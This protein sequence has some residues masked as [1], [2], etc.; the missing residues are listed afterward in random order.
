MNTL[1]EFLN[2]MFAIIFTLE[3]IVKILA[4]DKMYFID[5]WNIFDF[6]IVI[7]TIIGLAIGMFT[8]HS[9]GP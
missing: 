7:G 9:V 6:V 3:A 1:T 2:Y 8:A 5:G 4:Y